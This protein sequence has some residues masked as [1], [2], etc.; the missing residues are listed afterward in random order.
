MT[1]EVSIKQNKKKKKILLFQIPSIGGRN[2]I[3]KLGGAV[4]GGSPPVG[5]RISTSHEG[6][7]PHPGRPVRQP[8]RG[9]GGLEVPYSICC[10]SSNMTLIVFLST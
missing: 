4:A 3:G 8:D 1:K 6:D 9:K 2:G 7:R 10:L 5:R